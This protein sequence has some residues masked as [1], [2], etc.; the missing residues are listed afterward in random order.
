M[1]KTIMAATAVAV[2]LSGPVLA[3]QRQSQPQAD[4]RDTDDRPTNQ[5]T[6]ADADTIQ[7]AKVSNAQGERIGK[8]EDVVVDVKKGQVAYAIVGI[9][10]FL[11]VG[12]KNVAVP[13]DR[14]RPGQEAQSFVLNVDRQALQNA[15]SVERDKV[16]N[17]ENQ[18]TRR[19]IASFWSK[20]GG[21]AQ[22]AQTPGENR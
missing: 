8:I 10:G 19:D 5:L 20:A 1:L 4:N 21:A 15:P 3:Q 13:W 2:V 7:G 18:S 11:G 14:L 9:G 22:Q 12:E 17:L 16:A 6:L